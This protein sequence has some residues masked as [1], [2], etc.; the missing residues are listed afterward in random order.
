MPIVIILIVLMGAGIAVLA[1]FLIRSIIIPKR[2]DVLEAMLKQG[3]NQAVVKA[4]RQLIKNDARNQA[5][6]Y[7][8]GRAYLAD[9]KGELALM[10][11]KI[12]NQIANFGSKI[13]EV[14]FRTE[15][16]QLFVRY[17]QAEEA[18]KEYLL[19]IKLEP[20][21]SDH[22]YMAGKLFSERNRSDM[23]VNYLRKAVE[24]NPRNGL[25]L[26]ELGVLLYREKKSVEARSVLES[27]LRL[28]PDNHSAYYYLGKLQKDAHDYVSALLSFE[29]AQREP[30][31]KIRSLIERGGCYMSM[32][33]FDKAIPELERAIRNANDDG[34]Q[35]VLYARYFLAM[36]FEQNRELESAIGQ[37]E[38]IYNKK[39]GFR[40]VAEKLSHYQ[41]F[42]TDDK[43]KDFLTAGRE[44]F[45]EFCRQIVAKGLDLQVRD[46]KEIPNGVDIIAVKGDAGKW[47][48]VK[49][50]PF[51]IRILR[52]PEMIEE[53]TIRALLEEM[54]KQ[55]MIRCMLITSSGFTRTAIEYTNSRPIE[56]FHKDKLQELMKD[57]SLSANKKNS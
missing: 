11:Y 37:W 3:K 49:T 44:D 51:L 25:A 32:G 20:E 52:V 46:M 48:N 42:R 38:K 16:G 36:C 4:A 10:E 15:M 18:L 8:L 31:Y 1:T 9:N 19:L 56:L 33:S 13:E 39:P 50:Q 17:A 7:W 54:K 53:A 55:N 2:V 57:V 21:V 12:V 30:E 43:M 23:A 28:Q 6:H 29:K 24:L 5:A 47:R 26:Y 34:S 35:E 45:L 27:S 14:N 22:Y 40:D 41:E